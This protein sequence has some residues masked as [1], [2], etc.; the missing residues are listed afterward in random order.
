MRDCLT[1]SSRRLTEI[2]PD[3]VS[4]SCFYV[5]APMHCRTCQCEHTYT[6]SSG[7]TGGRQDRCTPARVF[8]RSVNIP[9][10]LSACFVR[11]VSRRTVL[12][13]GGT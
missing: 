13:H 10:V 5:V 12:V 11:F 2:A 9:E 6:Y 1:V 4:M 8:V 3:S 7:P